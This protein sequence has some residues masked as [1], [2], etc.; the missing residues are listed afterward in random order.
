MSLSP[1]AAASL[2]H[3]PEPVPVRSIGPFSGLVICVTGLS[4]EARKQV[5]EATE[6]LGGQY[7]AS[8]HPQCTHLVVQSFSGRKFDHA[9]K[10]GS[11]NS[12]FVVTLGWFVD[13]VKMNVRLSESLYTVKGVGDHGTRVDELNRLVPTASE[14]SCLPSGFHDAKK[15]DMV[16]KQHARFSRSDPKNSM[17]SMLSGHT[18]YIDS[19]ISDELRNKVLEAASKEGATVVDRWFVGCSASHVVCE[20]NSIHRYI[21][22]SNN[23]VTPLWVLKTSKDRFVPR[24]VHMSADLARQ[25]GTFL[26]TSRNGTAGEENNAVNFSQDTPSFRTNASHEERKQIVHLAKT[27]VRN[28]RNR[29][30]QTCQIPI[31]PISP[32]SLLDSICWSIS[33]PTSTASIFTD[34]CS[35]GDAS[36]HQSE[37]FDANGDGKD[38]GASFTNS[39]RSLTE[40][41]KNELIF[42]NHFLTILFP[43]DRFSEMGPSARTFFSDNGFTCLQENMS[44]HEIEAAIHTDSRHAGWLRAAYSSKETA[45]RGGNAIFKR[46]DFL[47]SRRSFEM[48]KRVSGDNNSNVY[49]L[50]IRA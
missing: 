44:G 29:R 23:I 48:L 24:L 28:R 21:G 40:S 10:H 7:S 25:I 18:L 4:K 41:E 37:F 33:E 5:M 46:I 15:I 14:S 38:S 13:S 39:T 19:D 47:G 50:L 32:S 1:V 8:L 35:G 2:G 34:S 16:E 42:K 26:E 3:E 17:Y 36:E 12:L 30:M 27:G 11:R 31:R 9:L 45:E 43:V 49:E 20:R 6:R 22:H